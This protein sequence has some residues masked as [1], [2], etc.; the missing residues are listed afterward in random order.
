[1]VDRAIYELVDYA[2]EKGFVAEM[3]KAWAVNQ[4]LDALQLDGIKERDEAFAEGKLFGSTEPEGRL[5]ALLDLL[6]DDAYARGV[7]KEVDGT[8]SRDKVF[9]DILNILGV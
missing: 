5:A 3:E 2:V 7:L 1:M 6:L 4:V 9:A 8:Q